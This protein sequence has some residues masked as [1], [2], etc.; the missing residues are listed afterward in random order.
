MLI[1]VKNTILLSL[2]LI[3]F[4]SISHYY[5][6]ETNIKKANKLRLSYLINDLD[7]LPLLENNTF[8]VIEYKDDVQNYIESK[9]KYS[10]E[11]LIE[12]TE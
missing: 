7:K 8:N 9:K 12:N 4:Y 10:F 2:T 6:S 3:F 1:K 11:K 5:F